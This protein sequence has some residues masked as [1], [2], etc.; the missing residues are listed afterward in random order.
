MPRK[1]QYQWQADGGPDLP[2]SP[3]RSAKKRH[4]HALQALGEELTRLAPA[5][6]QTMD[7]PPEMQEAL[8]LH[9]HIRDKEGKRRQ[10]QYIGRLMREVDAEALQTALEARRDAAAAETARFHLAEQWRERLLSVS[11]TELEALLQQL[12]RHTAARTPDMPDWLRLTQAARQEQAGQGESK[13]G[14]KQAPHA[15]RALFRALADALAP[16]S[17]GITEQ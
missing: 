7:L 6:W 5:D 16:A 13:T 2:E 4:C 12:A 15:R 8:R 9:A 1:K 17:T 11:E 10:L 3:S 14:R